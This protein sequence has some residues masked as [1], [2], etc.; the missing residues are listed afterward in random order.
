MNA[1]EQLEHIIAER[2]HQSSD[3]SYV[4][5]LH[6]KGRAK[7]AQKLGEE[8]V[9]LVI[10]AMADDKK[11]MVSE[12]ADFLFHWMVLLSEAGISLE[13]VLT[14]LQRRQGLSGLEEKAQRAGE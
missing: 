8:A 9:E 14:E 4:A 5:Q 12:S 11:Q 3:S 6:A 10:E 2:K 1:L 7:I 13:E